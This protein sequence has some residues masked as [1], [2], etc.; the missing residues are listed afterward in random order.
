MYVNLFQLGFA[1]GRH[2]RTRVTL[3]VL[4]EPGVTKFGTC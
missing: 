3:R 1:R 4:S 2:E